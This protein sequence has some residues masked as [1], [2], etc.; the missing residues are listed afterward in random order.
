[1]PHNGYRPFNKILLK[2]HFQ[3]TK[4]LPI[5]IGIKKYIENIRAS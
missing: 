4:I 2:R 1:M 3:E 5:K